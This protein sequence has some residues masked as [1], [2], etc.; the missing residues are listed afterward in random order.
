MKKLQIL[1]LFCLALIVF[2]SC[3]DDVDCTD[4][5]ALDTTDEV[6]A[7]NTAIDAFNLDNSDE[8]CSNLSEAY[9][10]FIDS[11]NGILDCAQDSTRT[12]IEDQISDAE[13][14]LDSLPC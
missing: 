2:T 8:N 6:A 12:V 1:T 9:E 10:S 14:D 4:P 13:A 11:L 3:G 7:V 5:T